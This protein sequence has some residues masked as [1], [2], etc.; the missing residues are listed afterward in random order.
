MHE[1]GREGIEYVPGRNPFQR[2][3]WNFPM[4][5][6]AKKRPLIESWKLRFYEPFRKSPKTSRFVGSY[7]RMANHGNHGYRIGCQCSSNKWVFPK[8]GVPQ[9]GWF[10]MENPIKMDDLG[11]KPTIFG[12]TQI[13]NVRPFL[14][15]WTLRGV[16]LTLFFRMGFL[17]RGILQSMHYPS[18]INSPFRRLEISPNFFGIG[19]YH[20]RNN[21]KGNHFSGPATCWMIPE[22]ITFSWKKWGCLMTG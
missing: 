20:R 4:K 11:G 5:K 2:S 8:I 10:I 3:W 9:N 16:W 12:N 6:D 17:T 1:T 14:T 21:S 13:S 15:H 18:R 7:I 19:K 22:C